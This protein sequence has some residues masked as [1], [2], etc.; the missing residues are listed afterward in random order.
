MAETIENLLKHSGP[1]LSSSLVE[2]LMKNGLSK[3]AARQRVSRA[4][5]SVKRL[6]GLQFPNRERFLFLEGQFGKEEFRENLTTALKESRTSYGRALISMESRGGAVHEPHFPIATGLP[7]ENAKGQILSALAVSRLE[8]VGMIT[9]TSTPDGDVIGLW[10]KPSISERRRAAITVEDV[11]LG[12]MKTWLAKIG[13]T[14]S[15]AV[16]S[17]SGQSVPKFGQFRFDLVGPSYLNA[18]VVY[19]KGQKI[20]GFI[21]ADILLDSQVTAEALEGFFSKWAV[22]TAQRRATRFQPIFI[23]ESFDPEALN[24]LRAKGCI[25]ACP[26]TIFGEEVAKQLR[27]LVETIAHA[28][29]AVTNNPQAV[30]EL[31]SKI[32]KLEGAAL[33]LRGVVLE[34]IV[35]HLFQ[36]RSYVIEIRQQIQSEQGERAEIDVRA[37]SRKE[38]V[39]VE[40]KGKAPGGLV[41]APEIEQWLNTSLPRIKSWLKLMTLPDRRRFEFYSSTGYTDEA[42]ALIAKITETHKKQPILFRTGRDVIEDLWEEKENALIDIFREQFGAK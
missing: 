35:A 7:V 31:L 3:D 5:G 38:V 19:R 11:V 15:G 24:D 28:A 27:D 36:R 34:L 18:I 20:N 13:W 40:C 9:R 21:F 6:G 25:V 33:N 42:I 32:N 1:A 17:R 26:E 12:V 23:G 30:F 2:R 37:T 39:C 16:Q 8:K 14:S 22:L 4:G 29:E 10:N 41:D